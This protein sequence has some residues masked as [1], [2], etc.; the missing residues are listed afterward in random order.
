MSTLDMDSLLAPIPGDLPCGEDLRYMQVYDDIKEARRADD[1]L[2]QGQW[3]RD[4]KASDWGKVIALSVQAL[5]DRTKDLQIGA[6]LTEALA[7]TEGF[8]GA[9]AGIRLLSGLLEKYWETVFP[10]I[11]D[12]DYDYRIAP[13]EFLNDKL[14]LC[15]KQVSL[16]EPGTTPG[17]SLQKWQE[18]LD[19]THKDQDKISVDEFDGAVTK[20]SV[21]FYQ[22]LQ[23]SLSRCMEAF[24]SLDTVIDGTFGR[25]APRISDMGQVLDDCNRLVR[26]ICRE[27][28]AIVLPDEQVPATEAEVNSEERNVPSAA[29]DSESMVSVQTVSAKAAPALTGRNVLSAPVGDEVSQ[30]VMAWDEALRMLQQGEVTD[31]LNRL[32]AL[33]GSQQ[34]ERGRCRYQFLVAKLCHKAGKADLARPILE[35]INT[36]INDLH[37]ELWESPS[38]IAEVFEL[39]YQ[40]LISGEPT[41]EDKGR[42]QELFKKICTLDVTKALNV[43]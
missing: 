25:H 7:Q 20:S 27:Q 22:N 28:K 8:E 33:A 4:I 40:C 6:W 5:T 31:A 11:E 18:S 39:L 23:E 32:L 38:W 30:E 35:R 43:K 1:V 15:F 34:S 14:N 21:K 29:G 10:L 42:S 2:P 3:Q 24:K 37:L 17:Y 41:S 26:K 36:L 12:D 16:T 19:T 9:E 13:F